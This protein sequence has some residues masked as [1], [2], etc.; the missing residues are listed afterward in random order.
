MEAHRHFGKSALG[1]RGLKDRNTAIL[2]AGASAVLAAALIYL[3]VTHYHKSAPV[4]VA[5][6]DATV[7]VAKQ[8]IPAGTSAAQIATDGLLKATQKPL[9]QVVPG[10][11]T[12]LSVVAGQS[13]AYAIAANDQATLGDFTRTAVNS[14]TSY[15]KGAERGVAFNLDGEHGLTSYLQPNSTVD[16]MAVTSSGASELLI[17]DVTIIANSNGLVVL[18][19]TD[20]QALLVTA[21]TTKYSLWLAMRPTIHATNSV[22]VGSVGTVGNI[23]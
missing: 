16:V 23:G 22:Q 8:P 17:K 21:A 13:T 5:P 7:W 6:Q 10:A 11:L 12:S 4:V 19:L 20:K 3:F 1:G 9:S 14:L 15:L 18:R 2:V